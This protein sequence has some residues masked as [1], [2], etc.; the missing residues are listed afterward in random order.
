ML[1]ARHGWLMARCDM[2]DD[3]PKAPA[4]KHYRLV[5]V[6]PLIFFGLHTAYHVGKGDPEN[7]L[8]GCHLSNLLIGMGLLTS[9]PAVLAVGLLWLSVGVPLW[10]GLLIGT[11]DEFSITSMLTHVGGAVVGIWAVCRM[12]WPRG[13]WWKAWLVIPL[14][15]LVCRFTTPPAANV[16][17]SHEVWKGWGKTFPSYP[18]YLILLLGITAVIFAVVEQGFLRLKFLQTPNE[19][20]NED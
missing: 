1:P 15:Q 14:L 5:G 12:N 17:I 10:I 6:L 3:T 20:E 4:S 11:P 9:R 8:W 7:M 16:N 13:T 2:N 18:V 19:S